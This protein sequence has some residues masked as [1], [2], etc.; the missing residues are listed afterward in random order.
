MKQLL[1]VIG[2]LMLVGCDDDNLDSDIRYSYGVPVGVFEKATNQCADANSN[3]D[4]VFI[5]HIE[6][7]TEYEPIYE[8]GKR[9]SNE[10]VDTTR[11]TFIVRCVSGAKFKTQTSFDFDSSKNLDAI[12]TIET[13]NGSY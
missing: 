3:V 4:R 2:L 5:T 10:R 11:Y 9:I 12:T 8:D 7:V 1:A 6:D 13:T